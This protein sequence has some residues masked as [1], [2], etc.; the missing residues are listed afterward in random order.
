MSKP[1]DVYSDADKRDIRDCA[2]KVAGARDRAI[3]IHRAYLRTYAKKIR[4]RAVVVTVSGGGCRA[5]SVA[6]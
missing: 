4:E 3:A 2:R 5:V 6:Q 1:P